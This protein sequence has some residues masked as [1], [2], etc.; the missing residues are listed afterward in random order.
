MVDGHD[1]GATEFAGRRVTNFELR[2]A[3]GKTIRLYELLAGGNWLD[4]EIASG[5]EPSPLPPGIAPE[6]VERD[7]A[8]PTDARSFLAQLRSV[9]IRPDGH[10][11]FART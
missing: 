9:L 1:V 7:S 8:R 6:W 5:A 3:D 4:L 11:A 10:V 2:R